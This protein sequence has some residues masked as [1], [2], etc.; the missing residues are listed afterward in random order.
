[1]VKA[2]RERYKNTFFCGGAIVKRKLQVLCVLAF[3]ILSCSPP[4]RSWFEPSN[5]SPEMVKPGIVTTPSPIFRE[6]K[7]L[8]LIKSIDGVPPTFLENKAVVPPGKHSFEVLA[9]LHHYSTSSER[10]LR[11]RSYVTRALNTLEITVEAQH[12]YLIDALE[13]RNGVWIWAMDV[14]DN[15]VVAGER[16]RELPK[17]KQ[18]AP[19]WRG[20][21]SLP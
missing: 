9:E 16:P 8:I 5:P 10:P 18:V 15:V 19:V 7:D 12:D 13:D 21:P 14:T 20:D 3:L 2:L 1:M 17:D 4:E 6:G 11:D